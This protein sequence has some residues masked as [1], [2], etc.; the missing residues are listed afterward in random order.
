MKPKV[1]DIVKVIVKT[2]SQEWPYSYG[3]EHKILTTNLDLFNNQQQ[4]IFD[5]ENDRFLYEKECI[6]IK[7]CKLH[8]TGGNV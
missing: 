6:V 8:S 5:I 4:Y 3:T 2:L 1:G 7:R